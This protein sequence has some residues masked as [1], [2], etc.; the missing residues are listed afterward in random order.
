MMLSLLFDYMIQAKQ[1]VLKDQQAN[2]IKVLDSM[3]NFY[4]EMKWDFDSSVLPFISKLAPSGK[5]K[6]E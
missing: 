5:T 6:K 3:P 4:L 2:L 1:K